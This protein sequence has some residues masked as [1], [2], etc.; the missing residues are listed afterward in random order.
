MRTPGFVLRTSFCIAV[1]VLIGSPTQ[2][3]DEAP[4]KATVKSAAGE[5]GQEFQAGRVVLVQYRERE[6]K[7]DSATGE[8]ERAIE[9][10]VKMDK[11]GSS[12]RAARKM[13]LK[14][15][16]LD[17]LQPAVRQRAEKVLKSSAMFRRLPIMS[18]GVEPAVYRFFIRHPDVAVSIWRTMKISKFQMWQTGPMEYE[19][20]A[21]DGTIGAIDVLYR[22]KD[23][24]VVVCNGTYKS[25][26]LIKPI[27]STAL[28]HLQTKFDR[29]PD[30]KEYVTHR[31]DLF[32]AFPSQTV[33]TAAKIVAPVSNIII[34]RNF[35]EISLFLHMMSLAMQ[36]QPGWVEH[37][38]NRLEGILVVRKTQLRDLTAQVYVAA[39]K[40]KSSQAG[41]KPGDAS[42]EKTARDDSPAVARPERPA[43]VVV[44]PKRTTASQ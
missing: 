44:K 8:S 14:E 30:G 17:K 22:D 18:F 37:L 3:F 21:D 28:I 20:D 7:S 15:F 29:M 13:A 9:N 12:G 39:R 31:V 4:G 43:R 5:E 6:A 38:T 1:G 40:R 11:K 42:P 33:K 27:K 24:C 19:A 16:P 35:R 25:P 26:L 10:H 41:R 32:V 2:A 34:D 23:R 36:K